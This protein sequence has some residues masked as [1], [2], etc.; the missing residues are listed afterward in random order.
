MPVDQA[1]NKRSDILNQSLIPGNPY[2]SDD[3]SNSEGRS[4]DIG[5]SNNRLIDENSRISEES[6][7][8]NANGDFY[9][10]DG[11]IQ[12]SN[13]IRTISFGT[14]LL[15]YICVT[16]NV[17]ALQVPFAFTTGGWVSVLFVFA[18]FFASV[19]TGI[20]S[21]QCLQ[22]N[23]GTYKRNFHHIAQFAFGSKG[24]TASLIMSNLNIMSSCIVMLS[25]VGS[26]GGAL[27]STT[28]RHFDSRVW[29]LIFSIF[30][31]LMFLTL[32]RF[33]S[34]ARAV[35][36][37]SIYNT[38]EVTTSLEG[39]YNKDSIKLGSDGLA[40]IKHSF[41]SIYFPVSFG[42]CGYAF[43]GSAMHTIIQQNMTTPKNWPIVLVFGS[44]IVFVLI[45]LYGSSMYYSFGDIAST[46]AVPFQ[47]PIRF[48]YY[49]IPASCY[50]RINSWKLCSK[51][52]KIGTIIV[53]IV[54]IFVSVFGTAGA[55]FYLL[56]GTQVVL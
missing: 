14:A 49:I 35:M 4:A 32:R 27:F 40:I 16:I 19:I 3:R 18:C 46:A 23:Q 39:Y 34:F 51:F 25:V 37:F 47:L 1:S 45:T 44:F 17:G 36:G 43:G 31:L 15:L 56:Y 22:F 10:N 29:M 20:M 28:K 38:F 54:G 30:I 7:D 42:F 5:I 8:F 50:L 24:Y 48:V 13:D 11:T 6:E 33:Y 2:F 41:A 53:I 21:Y 26:I 12:P 55:V 9:F 52:E